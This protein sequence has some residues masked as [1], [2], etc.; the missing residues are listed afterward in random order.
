MKK[1]IVVEPADIKKILAE[2]FHVREDAVIK[3]QYS[4]TV[5]MEGEDE[6]EESDRDRQSGDRRS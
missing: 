3:S 2:K 6:P 4:Y 1:A 5:V